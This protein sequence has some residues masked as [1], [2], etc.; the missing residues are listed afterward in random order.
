ME[1]LQASDENIVTNAT[2]AKVCHEGVTRAALHTVTVE[3]KLLNSGLIIRD[4]C[5]MCEVCE[6]CVC[7]VGMRGDVR[8]G[9][10]ACV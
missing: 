5:V 9:R 4:A 6:G 7:G 2:V 8:G 10:G 1:F 3:S